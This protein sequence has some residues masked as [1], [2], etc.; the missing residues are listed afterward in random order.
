MHTEPTPSHKASNPDVRYEKT[1]GTVRPLYIFLSWILGVTIAS[2]AF[3]WFTLGALEKWYESDPKRAI[4]AEALETQQPPAPRI[5]TRETLDLAAFKKEE[6]GILSTYGVVDKE[7]GTFRIP[8]DEAVRLTVL[9]G[10]PVAALTAPVATDVK[11][12]K[13]VNPGKPGPSP[14]PKI[15]ATPKPAIPVPAKVVHP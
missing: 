6:A 7:K 1:D 11:P 4:M 10:L 9:R 3:A 13:D 12:G 2:A 8:I 14:S 5:Q 15:A